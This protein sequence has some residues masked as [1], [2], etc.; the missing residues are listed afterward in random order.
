MEISEQDIILSSKHEG[1]KK[2]FL[3]RLRFILSFK[4]DEFFKEEDEERLVVAS[5]L[6]TRTLKEFSSSWTSQTRD[7]FAEQII[8]LILDFRLKIKSRILLAIDLSF[9]KFSTPNI[10]FEVDGE[11]V[12]GLFSKDQEQAAFRFLAESEVEESLEK[13]KELALKAL[14]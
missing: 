14:S 9:L 8:S 1:T 3:T 11:E 5:S 13:A 7:L 2:K 6:I 12:T 4:T 10:V